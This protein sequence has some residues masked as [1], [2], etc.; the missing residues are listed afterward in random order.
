MASLFDQERPLWRGLGTLAD[1]LVLSAMWFTASLPLFTLG[2]ST[3][4]LYDA[5]S[6]CLRGGDSGPWR[7]FLR[8]FRRELPPSSLLTVVFGF[9]LV[10]LY[11]GLALLWRGQVAGISGAPVMLAV[12]AVALIIPTGMFLWMWPLLSRFTF[13]PLALVKTALQ[14]TFAHLLST[15]I[16]VVVTLFSVLV[17][18]WL[19]FPMLFL[20]CLTAL[21]WTVPVERAFRRHLPAEDQDIMKAIETKP[22][23]APVGSH[24][25]YIAAS[26]FMKV[27]TTGNCGLD[28]CV[29]SDYYSYR[30][31][32]M[33]NLCYTTINSQLCNDT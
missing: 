21:V 14:F 10:L 19:L 5:V 9:L 8:T 23:C 2:A 33:D 30:M 25:F 12:Y 13:T 32:S 22:V 17:T 4:A 26:D 11:R 1:V 3:T 20:P 28:T 29:I 6:H 7:R 16:L 18:A 24:G 15:V 31:T 27:L